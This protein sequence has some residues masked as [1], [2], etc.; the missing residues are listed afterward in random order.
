MRR[1]DILRLIRLQV[2]SGFLSKEPLEYS[3]MKTIPPVAYSSSE[4][5]VKSKVPY[6]RLLEKVYDKNPILRDETVFPGFG[7]LEPKALVLAKKQYFY[8]QQGLSEAE[9]YKKASQFVEDLEDEALLDLKEIEKEVKSM[10]ASA[11][12]LSD[13]EIAQELALWQTTLRSTSYEKLTL[14]EQGKLDRFVQT[15]IL[16]WSELERERRMKDII[17][18]SQFEHLLQTLFPTD[19]SVTQAKRAEFQKTFGERFLALHGYDIEGIQTANAFLLE[20]YFQFFEKIRGLPNAEDWSTEEY[21]KFEEWVQD[22]LA[23]SAALEE[24]DESYLDDIYDQFFPSLMLPSRAKLLK[25]PTVD[26]VRQL[27]YENQIGYKQ[28]DG[29]LFVKRF[30]KLPRLLFPTDVFCAKVARNPVTYMY[31]IRFLVFF[32]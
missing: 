19:E 26:E 11:P 21:E 7:D 6:S 28:I 3:I 12:F 2:K 1:I 18:Y 4:V 5:T 14:L 10:G 20:D 31:V 24:D 15:K 22:T 30:Y 13:P 16:K 9:A 17:F 27:L 8:M 32:C 29:K 23:F 25:L